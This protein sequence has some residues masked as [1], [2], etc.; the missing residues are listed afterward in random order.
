MSGEAVRFFRDRCLVSPGG[1]EARR[2]CLPASR[3]PARPPAPGEA[4]QRSPCSFSAC[5]NRL[6]AS[7]LDRGKA[8]DSGGGGGAAQ[9]MLP[10]SN[11]LHSLAAETPPRRW[12][13]RC[14]RKL[15]PKEPTEQAS[16]S[17][18]TPGQALESGSACADAV[19]LGSLVP[20]RL[21][22][23]RKMAQLRPIA[24]APPPPAGTASRDAP[25]A[26]Q[27]NASGGE[28]PE[29]RVAADKAS[30]SPS[31]D[32]S[33]ASASDFT[34][35]APAARVAEGL[36]FY[37][38]HGV[39]GVDGDGSRGPPPLVFAAGAAGGGSAA[40]RTSEP[41]GSVRGSRKEM[42]SEAGS[43]KR[44]GQQCRGTSFGLTPAAASALASSASIPEP[45][46]DGIDQPP[47]PRRLFV[48]EARWHGGS[49]AYGAGEG[50]EV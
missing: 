36:G 32:R 5:A 34:A 6:V 45:A 20:G 39:T 41:A 27:P 22:V 35:P 19:G 31:S 50:T 28:L 17:R 1:S 40:G 7:L 18:G 9:D 43:C 11:S 24:M 3:Q 37:P 16:A 2:P 33:V 8:V 23:A 47:P 46:G 38:R 49:P 4:N 30:S 13:S 26:G 10:R 44:E 15:R 48:N 14:H 25:P 12:H 42:H 29:G 21:N